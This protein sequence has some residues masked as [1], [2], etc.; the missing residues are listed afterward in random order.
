MKLNIN[1]YAQHGKDT[2]ADLFCEE[3]KLV[4]VSASHIYA[5]LIRDLGV[6]GP[7][8][9]VEACY[10]DRVNHRKEWYN[11][12]RRETKSNPF[13]FVDMCLY[14]G[15]MYVGHRSQWEF[16]QTRCA[17]DATI[18]VDAS[19]RGMPQEPEDSCDLTVHGHDYVIDNGMSLAVTRNQVKMVI[20]LINN[21]KVALNAYS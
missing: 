1:G 2:V 19:G 8:E 3:A 7:Y 16:E 14:E 4:K 21:R 5:R 20:R 11:F 17:F 9:S 10:Q 12:I 15:D 13:F 18:W 6:L